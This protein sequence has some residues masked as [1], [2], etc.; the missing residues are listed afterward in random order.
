[1]G[2][3]TMSQ[4]FVDLIQMLIF[5]GFFEEIEALLTTPL[6]IYIKFPDLKFERFFIIHIQYPIQI[7]IS[8]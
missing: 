5:I 2:V 1:M 6:Y 3:V 4:I 8:Q 7:I